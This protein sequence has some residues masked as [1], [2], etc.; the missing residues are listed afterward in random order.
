MTKPF[1]STAGMNNPTTVPNMVP[2][3]P[4]RLVPPMTTAA[5]TLRL[6]WDWPAIAVVPYWDSDSMPANPARVPESAKVR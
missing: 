4:K 1:C 2:M 5:M 6:V 3:P